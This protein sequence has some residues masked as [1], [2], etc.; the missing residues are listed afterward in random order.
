MQMLNVSDPPMD[1][2]HLFIRHVAYHSGYEGAPDGV[3]GILPKD[4]TKF[5]RHRIFGI[6]RLGQTFHESVSQV[7]VK[8]D[9]LN[10]TIFFS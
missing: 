6:G 1:V 4:L 5:D 7:C 10:L 3:R 8:L 9:K 2:V